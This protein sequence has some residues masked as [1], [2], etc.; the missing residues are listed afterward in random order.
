MDH[1]STNFNNFPPMF[2]HLKFD[3]PPLS[4]RAMRAELL[5]ESF[6]RVSSRSGPSRRFS[7]R[8]SSV[9][10]RDH[11]TMTFAPN[12]ISNTPIPPH[13]ERFTPFGPRHRT[14]CARK[15]VS[16]LFQ[17]LPTFHIPQTHPPYLQT[18]RNRPMRGELNLFDHEIETA[19]PENP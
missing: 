11:F 13:S 1:D 10:R 8:S 3:A 14:R 5:R 7:K 4:H 19:L 2:D 16:M 15:P 17:T 9:A 12:I 18:T 6:L